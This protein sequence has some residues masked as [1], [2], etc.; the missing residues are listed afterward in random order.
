SYSLQS[1]CFFVLACFLSPDSMAQSVSINSDGAAPDNSAM[2]DIQSTNKGLL[3]PRMSTAERLGITSPATG[4]LVYDTD[5]GC[6]WY[7]D[8]AWR[9]LSEGWS[10]QGI[11]DID[12]SMHFIGINHSMPILFKIDGQ[13]AGQIDHGVR[14]NT[15]L[16]GNSLPFN[17]TGGANTGIG[18]MS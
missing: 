11:H 5:T 14:W 12:T 4:L 7:Y 17:G 13:P 6:F 15:S 10:L 9:R 16:G 8:S 1:I 2:L 18:A 3:I